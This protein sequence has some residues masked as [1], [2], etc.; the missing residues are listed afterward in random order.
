MQR[1]VFQRLQRLGADLLGIVDALLHSE[2]ESHAAERTREYEMAL[3]VIGSGADRA[4][5][6]L[7][8]IREVLL[9]PIGIGVEFTEV[10]RVA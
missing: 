6:V 3:G 1:V 9:S 4:A 8:S 7:L 10:Y 5:S 2:C